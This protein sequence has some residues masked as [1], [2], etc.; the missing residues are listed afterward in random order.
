MNTEPKSV[1]PDS[2][3]QQWMNLEELERLALSGGC[4][5]FEFDRA[6]DTLGKHPM[7]I[8]RY[9]K[10]HSFVPATFEIPEGGHFKACA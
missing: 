5:R 8:A 9:L 1:I 6:S 10:R 3:L 4:T 2:L 7:R